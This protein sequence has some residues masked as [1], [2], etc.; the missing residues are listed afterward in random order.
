MGRREPVVAIGYASWGGP[1][2]A[3]RGGPPGREAICC[4]TRATKCSYGSAGGGG[5][6]GI[7]S[8]A[9]VLSWG[10]VEG[11]EVG[12]ETSGTGPDEVRVGGAVND[13]D[14]V[15]EEVDRPSDVVGLF[16]NCPEQT[17]TQTRRRR[18]PSGCP[19][20]NNDGKP[21]L[22]TGIRNRR[23]NKFWKIRTK[24]VWHN[25][26]QRRIPCPPLFSKGKGK[27]EQ[28]TKFRSD[29]N[30]KFKNRGPP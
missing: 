23:I 6:G 2:A 17:G 14:G 8:R 18:M 10:T 21:G 15:D 16:A 19:C 4:D 30:L 3:C 27:R 13:E 7:F 9:T 26:E 20:W 29:T 1:A 11:D 5:G 24:Y 22:S 25:L 28:R 12:A